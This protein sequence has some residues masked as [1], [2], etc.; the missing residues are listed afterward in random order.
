MYAVDAA[1]VQEFE[2]A[3]CEG[4]NAHAPGRKLHVQSSKLY[5][6]V[7]EVLHV[8]VSRSSSRAGL[9]FEAIGRMRRRTGHHAHSA[10]KRLIFVVL[11]GVVAFAGKAVIM[12]SL[13]QSQ[14]AVVTNPSQF[15]VAVRLGVKHIVIVEH[16]DM[17]KTPRFSESTVMDTAMIA[18]VSN[19]EGENTT[20]IRV[21][22]H[23]HPHATYSTPCY[24]VPDH[25]V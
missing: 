16:L 3:R 7:I 22:G 15:Q 8:V 24:V 14:A 9:E 17:T 20:S 19:S 13:T 18:I 10:I 4:V 25:A 5:I 21:R 23:P 11:Y 6:L 12:A 1:A 2:L